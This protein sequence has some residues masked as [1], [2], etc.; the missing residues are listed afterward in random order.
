MHAVVASTLGVIENCALVC[1]EDRH[2][3][4]DATDLQKVNLIGNEELKLR[5]A[6]FCGRR[7]VKVL[8]CKPNARESLGWNRIKLKDEA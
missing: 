1:K 8:D 6:A 4:K 3:N 2:R 7:M 5:N